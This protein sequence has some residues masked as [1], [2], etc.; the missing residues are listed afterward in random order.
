GSEVVS[1]Y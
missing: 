1:E